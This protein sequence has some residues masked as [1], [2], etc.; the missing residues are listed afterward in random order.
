MAN[1]RQ[2]TLIARGRA[3]A[4]RFSEACDALEAVRREWDSVDGGNWCAGYFA[5][6]DSSVD[7]DEFAA[8]M[9]TAGALTAFL[10]QGHR[11]NVNRVKG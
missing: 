11:T 2:G 9:A 4:A 8:L 6:D 3:A 10:D 5:K 7:R 1:E